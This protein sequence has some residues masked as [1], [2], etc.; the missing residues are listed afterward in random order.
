MSAVWCIDCLS[1]SVI[2]HTISVA[3][4]GRGALEERALWGES[5]TEAHIGCSTLDAAGA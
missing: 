1:G 3:L 4:W 2:P 5:H